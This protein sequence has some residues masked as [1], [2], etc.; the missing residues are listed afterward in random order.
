MKKELFAD[1]LQSLQEAKDIAT[2]KM[3]PSRRF[4]VLLIDGKV[5]REQLGL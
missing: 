4:E 1:L 3:P 5:V 2:G